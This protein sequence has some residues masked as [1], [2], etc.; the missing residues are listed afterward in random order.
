MYG[1]PEP[2]AVGSCGAGVMTMVINDAVRL[3]TPVPDS[4]YRL[5][6]CKCGNDQPVYVVGC[7]RKWRVMCLDCKKET[8]GFE[9][10]H[11]AQTDWNR[12]VDS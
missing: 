9:V 1:A 7:D 11:D 5:K 4:Q 12:E 6:A 2:D 10:Q 8:K 3:V